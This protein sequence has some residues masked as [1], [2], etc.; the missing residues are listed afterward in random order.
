MNTFKNAKA[1]N[2]GTSYATVY[3]CPAATTAIVMGM[4]FS[5]KLATAITVTVRLHDDSDAGAYVNLSATNTPIE[6]G[7]SLVISG[8]DQKIVLEANDRIEVISSDASSVDA[9]GSVLQLS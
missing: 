8:G 3:T 5:N 4:S 2:V 6:P 1:V 7:G 9:F